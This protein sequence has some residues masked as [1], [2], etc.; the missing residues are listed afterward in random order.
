MYVHIQ[1]ALYGC[2]NSALFFY[3]KLVGDLEA[4]RFE[5]NPYDPCVANKKLVPWLSSTAT[6]V[7]WSAPVARVHP[8]N[9]DH[10]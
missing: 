1:K 4:H 2:L 5:I 3:E 10:R 8:R 6:L 9:A 7:P